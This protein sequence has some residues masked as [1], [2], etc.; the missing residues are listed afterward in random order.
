LQV[1]S[2]IILPGTEF[3]SVERLPFIMR[4]FDQEY[5]ICQRYHEKSYNPWEAVALPSQ[6]GHIQAYT[7]TGIG[8]YQH[9]GPRF[10]VVKRAQPTV[11]L[12]NLNSG[13]AGQVWAVSA[14]MGV[15][16]QAEGVGMGGFN[17][18]ASLGAP[19]LVR[20]HFTA[21]ARLP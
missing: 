3:P 11:I 19:D 10:A 6:P 15:A 7:V 9:M 2:V 17:F 4:P 20:F 16:A 13:L 18:Y 5:P 14:N 8:A 21:D 1:T 12:Y